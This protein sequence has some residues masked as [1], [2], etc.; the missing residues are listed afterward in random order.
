[1]DSMKERNK[2]SEEV[3][4]VKNEPICDSQFISQTKVLVNKIKEEPI[5][6]EMQTFQSNIEPTSEEVQVKAEEKFSATEEFA[7]KISIAFLNDETNQETSQATTSYKS[8]SNKNDK[9]PKSK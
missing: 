8:Q 1:M 4:R 6:I 3:D 2:V 9:L 5:E 7:N